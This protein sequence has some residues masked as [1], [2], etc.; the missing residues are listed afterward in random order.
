L[1]KGSSQKEGYDRSTRNHRVAR[2]SVPGKH[3]DCNVESEDNAEIEL[4]VTRPAGRAKKNE[5]VS[6]NEGYRDQQSCAKQKDGGDWFDE[7]ERSS[8]RC[9]L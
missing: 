4:G 2:I 3:W 5:L 8:Q 9:T 6:F 1:K 7:E